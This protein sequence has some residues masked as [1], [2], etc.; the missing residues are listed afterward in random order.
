MTKRSDGYNTRTRQLILDYLVENRHHAVSASHILDELEQ[1]G[2]AP[3]PTTVYRYLDKLVSEQRVMKYVADK[4]EKAVFQYV[5]QG[6]R[7]R[8]HLHLKCVKCGQIDHLE[9]DFMEQLR[10]HLEE[11][12]GFAL[13][14]EGSMLYGVC[15]RCRRCPTGPE[16]AAD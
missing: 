6:R 7:C 15:S 13:Q 2:A 8:E 4:G 5:E 16:P 14:C 10:A 3:N 1:Q 9:C 11:E 12:H